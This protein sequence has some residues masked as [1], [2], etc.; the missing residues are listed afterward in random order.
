MLAINAVGRMSTLFLFFILFANNIMCPNAQ[1]TLAP[2][3][4]PPMYTVTQVSDMKNCSYSTAI[5]AV[6]DMLRHV[7]I[8]VV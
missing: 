2:T 5:V 4:G 1:P 6:A 7:L 3:A 8:A